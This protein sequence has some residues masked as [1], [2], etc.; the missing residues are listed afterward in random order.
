MTKIKGYITLLSVIVVGVIS[1]SITIALILINVDNIK[2]TIDY[3]NGKQAEYLARACGEIALEKIWNDGQYM[4]NETMSLTN[5]SCQIL[6]VEDSGT[7]TPTIK[8]V[9]TSGLSVKR[10]EISLSQATP[11]IEI[12]YYREKGSF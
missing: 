11:Q 12:S 3:E 1:M 7:Q 9:G 5:G 2:T 10:F 4:G 6:A 8:V